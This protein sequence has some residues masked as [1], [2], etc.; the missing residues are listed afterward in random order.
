MEEVRMVLD[1]ARKAGVATH[2]LAWRGLVTAVR[3]TIL[4][5]AIGSLE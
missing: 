1:T 2:L 5:G 3:Q 4:D